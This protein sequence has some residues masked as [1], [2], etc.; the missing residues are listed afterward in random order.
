MRS[1]CEFGGNLNAEDCLD[2]VFEN[3]G[4]LTVMD[5][6]VCHGTNALDDCAMSMGSCICCGSKNLRTASIYLR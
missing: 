5:A 6:C 4:T 2:L 1:D 3:E